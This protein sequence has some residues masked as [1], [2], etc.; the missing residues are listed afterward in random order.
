MKERIKINGHLLSQFELHQL[1]TIVTAARWGYDA[2]E[3]GMGWTEAEVTIKKLW[4]E[5]IVKTRK[6]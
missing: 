6:G 3:K 5:A 2:Y 1:D 4:I